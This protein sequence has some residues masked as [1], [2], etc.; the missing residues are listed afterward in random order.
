MKNEESANNGTLTSLQP[1]LT[2][3]SG[4][5]F[6]QLVWSPHLSAMCVSR[7]WVCVPYLRLASTLK[8]LKRWFWMRVWAGG[9][10]TIS[11]AVSNSKIEKCTEPLW[12]LE[13]LKEQSGFSYSRLYFKTDRVGSL[14]CK[15]D[16]KITWQ[17]YMTTLSNLKGTLVHCW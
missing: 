5:I 15:P 9:G 4:G 1:G 11:P 3:S 8:D 14:T 2:K 10:G 7:T 17:D 13:Q 16:G 6:W 12:S